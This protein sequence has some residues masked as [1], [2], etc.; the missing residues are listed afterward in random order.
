MSHSRLSDPKASL[1]PLPQTDAR[2]CVLSTCS[3]V[4]VSPPP[5]VVVLDLPFLSFLL[6][7]FYSFL[8]RA[9][10]IL[11]SASLPFSFPAAS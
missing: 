10:T 8:L 2:R 5:V 4:I 7:S 3:N 1:L 11:I 9:L 6:S